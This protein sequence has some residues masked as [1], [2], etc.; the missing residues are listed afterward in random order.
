MIKYKLS[1][2]ENGEILG[3]FKTRQDAADA[4]NQYIAETNDGLDPS[5]E[6][7]LTPFDFDL[8]EVE[9][10]EAP[11]EIIVDYNSAREY[12]G[13]KANKQFTVSQRVANMNTVPG[14]MDVT[15]LVDALNPSHVEALIALNELFTIAQAW[16]K[17]DDFVPDYSDRR[18]AKWFPWFVYDK[19]RAGFVSAYTLTAPSNTSADFGSRLCFK[20]ANRARQFGEQ[21]IDLWNKVLLF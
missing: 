3:Q 21:F 15:R 16:N 1:N 8:E 14:L 18:Q 13:G 2:A 10:K 7:W 17:A 12:L 6:E 4:M 9:V 11:N 19:D 20:T 5:D